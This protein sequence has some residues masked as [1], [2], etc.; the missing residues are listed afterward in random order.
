MSRSRFYKPMLAQPAEQ[1]FTDAEWIFEI[2][3]DGFRAIA[4]VEEPFSLR[5]RNGKELKQNFPELTQLTSLAKN[6][7]L[8]GEIVVMQQG[9]PDFQA[10]LKRGQAVSTGVIQ[11]QSQRA[12]AVYIVFDILEKDGVALTHLPLTERKAI[13][14]KSLKEGSNVLLCDFIETKGEAYYG[15]ILEKGLEGVVAKRKS[16]FY[17]EGL[18]TGNWLKIKKLKTCDS[19][20]FGY[21]RGE[22]VRSE[23][24]GALLLGLYDA[25]GKPVYVG[26][27]GTGFSEENLRRLMSKFKKI[28]TDQAPFKP[29]TGDVVTWLQPKLVAEVAYQV[30]TKDGRLRMARFK[31]LREDKPPEQCTLDQLSGAPAKP[32][33]PKQVKSASDEQLS[34]YNAK[35][36]FQQTPEPVGTPDKKEPL[37]YVIQEHN[38]TRLHW[39]FRLEHGGVLKSWA[40]PK[41]I[42]EAPNVRH[43]AVETEDHPY[44]YAKFEGTIPKG[45]Y[46]A[47]TVKIWDRGHYEIK[48]WEKDKIEVIL[49]GERLHGNYVLIRLKKS[50]D[51]KNWLLLKGKDSHA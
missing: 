42:P 24:F 21:T 17:E 49:N 4:Y 12:P 36:N 19:I 7:V 22:N 16:S 48:A 37:I 30:V 15:L 5:S 6:V 1:A 43:L 34:E 8:D 25:A 45:Q 13:L 23:T 11:R 29:E 50:E 3:W 39:D 27:V 2:K 44:E 40:V 31:R 35:R 32:D 26:K 41:G 9:V 18:R 33:V 20:I 38:A 46:G 14:Q 10:L 28:T 51:Q 47:G